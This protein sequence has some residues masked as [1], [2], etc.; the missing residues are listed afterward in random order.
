MFI[1]F[2]TQTTAEILATLKTKGLK[3]RF[4]PGKTSAPATLEIKESKYSALLSELVELREY[5]AA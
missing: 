4:K 5:L 1:D 3:I 2:N